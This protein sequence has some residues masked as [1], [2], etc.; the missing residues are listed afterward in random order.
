MTRLLISVRDANEA[1]AAIAGGADLID[2]KEPRRG[3]LGCAAPETLRGIRRAVAGRRPLSAALGELE[4]NISAPA[5]RALGGYRYAKIGLASAAT[6]ENWREKW[7]NAV[8]RMPPTVSPVAV[9]YADARRCDAPCATDVLAGAIELSCRAILVDTFIKDGR[10]LWDHWSPEEGQRFLESAARA[11]LLTVLAGS[12]DC[13][14]ASLAAQLGA[15]V[16]AVR[17]CVC[18]NGRS[19]K[20][21]CSLVAELAS[22]VRKS[23][24]T[25]GTTN[26]H[27]AI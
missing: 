23:T 22:A 10:S 27:R 26:F 4:D 24:L 16:V 6:R 20:V 17:G 18:R 7:A 5:L 9:V 3:S 15:D 11:G 12:L 14:G 13:E 19:G 25:G 21:D 1:E 2:V 8:K